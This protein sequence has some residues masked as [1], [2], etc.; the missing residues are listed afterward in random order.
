MG[1]LSR[2]AKMIRAYHGSPHDFDRFEFSPRTL[3][4]GEGAQAYGNGL[5]FAENEAVARAYKAAL[6][7]P[8]QGT[9]VH[10]AAKEAL[11]LSQGDTGR[12]LDLLNSKMRDAYS[13][14]NTWEARVYQDAV[15]NFDQVTKDLPGRMYEVAIK[16]DPEEFLNWDA[17]LKSQPQVMERLAQVPRLSRQRA[18]FDSEHARGMNAY[19]S[20]GSKADATE[21]LRDAGI[22]GVRYFDQG[23]R[24]TQAMLDGKPIAVGKSWPADLAKEALD[25][26]GSAKEALASLARSAK[27]G[28]YGSDAARE[29]AD[30][31]RSG[32]IAL[33]Q[34]ERTSNYVVFDDKLIDIL[35]KYGLPIG[36]AGATGGLLSRWNG[37]AG[38]EELRGAYA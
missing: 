8:Y 4:T 32:R 23:S 22:P 38:D 11:D 5:Y 1:L 7:P 30:L 20:A 3:G 21:A 26:H 16:A 17:T 19:L 13:T 18:L 9:Q 35:R 14:G 37:S 28:G 29:A 10:M 33:G 27:S 31:I 2:A 24:Q 12:A 34:T 25:L 36:A 6:A 15:N